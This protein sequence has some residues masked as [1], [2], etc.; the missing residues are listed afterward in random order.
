MISG[1]LGFSLRY[2][3]P[4]HLTLSDTLSDPTWPPC[5]PTPKCVYPFNVGSLS[6]IRTWHRCSVLTVEYLTFISSEKKDL[7]LCYLRL[8]IMIHIVD[9]NVCWFII[10][11]N[12]IW[13]L[14]SVY[15]ALL[16]CSTKR[17]HD[18]TISR[19]YICFSWKLCTMY[20]YINDSSI[21]G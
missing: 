10:F 11:M 5:H 17:N 15:I 6:G 19:C 4:P 3:P 14:I 13:H 1:L 21:I 16:E 9:K 12:A 20:D 2:L 8:K 18:A 7:L